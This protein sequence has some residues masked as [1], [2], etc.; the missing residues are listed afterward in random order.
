MIPLV[1]KSVNEVIMFHDF[2]STEM[3]F[4]LVH[5]LLCSTTKYPKSACK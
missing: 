5:K 1:T 2:L 4:F 3:I